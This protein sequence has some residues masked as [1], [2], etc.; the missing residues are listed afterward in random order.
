MSE[1]SDDCDM[2]FENARHDLEK[3]MKSDTIKKS[4]K[5]YNDDDDDFSSFKNSKDGSKKS[6]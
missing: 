5:K 3:D 1:V 6:N 2:D 4:R